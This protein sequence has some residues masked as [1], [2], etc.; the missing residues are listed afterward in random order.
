MHLPWINIASQYYNHSTMKLAFNFLVFTTFNVVRVLADPYVGFPFDEQLP[1]IAR[2]G[3]NYNFII[4]SQTFKS[5]DESSKIKYEAFD[6]PEWLSFDSTSLSLSGL[7]GDDQ[8]SGKIDFILQGSDNQSSSNQSCSIYLSN[9]PSPQLNNDNTVMQQLESIGYT[10]GYN[11]IILTPQEPFKITF[12]KNT[13]EI[14]SSSNN[15]IIAYY[16]KSANRTS[17]PSWCFFDE[18]SL[19]FSGVAPAINSVDAPSMEFD[20]TLIATDY[21]GFSAIYSDFSIVVGG[22]SLYIKNS[23][24]YEASIMTNVGDSFQIDLP[25]DEIYL[26]DDLIQ[27]NQIESVQNYNGPS[28]VE[29]V[30]NSKIIGTVPSDQTS[31]TV[32]NVTLFDIYGDSIFMNFDINVLHNVF[33]IDSISNITAN[34]GSF[35]KFTLPD[36][37]FLNE[38]ATEL[39]VSFDADWLT[40]YHSNNTFIGQVP[41]NF[42]YVLVELDATINNMKQSMKFFI[43]GKPLTSSSLSFYSSSSSSS[44]RSSSMYS[45]KITSSASFVS[46]NY[47]SMI[48]LTKSFT[49]SD[50]SSTSTTSLST[51][52]TSS[53]TLVSPNNNNKGTNSDTK[54]KIAIALGVAIPLIAIIVA[55]IFIF[56]CCCAKRRKNS[57]DDDEK[58][59]DP[60]TNSMFMNQ[61][62]TS[63]STLTM[64]TTSARFLAE[65]NLNNLEKDDDLQSSYY[66]NAQ[67]TLTDESNQNLYTSANQQ[68]STDHLLGKHNQ[69]N[70]DSGIFNSWRKSSNGNLMTRDSLNSLATVATSDLLTVNVVSND[71]IRKSQMMLPSLSKLR[72]INNST[73]SLFDT[74]TNRTN[75]KD[76]N[77]NLPPLDENEQ[78]NTFSRDSS[79]NSLNSEAQL[80]GFENC[81][82]CSKNIQ[83]EEKSYHA[84][85][86]N[87]NNYDNESDSSERL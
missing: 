72:N 81:G 82:S 20:L 55:G 65:K 24:Y 5:N 79:Y 84:E 7:P 40:F 27:S 58:P 75:S 52:P 44:S 8:N 28:W 83:R 60:P 11:G 80:I 3:E 32:V 53:D 13:F 2:I 9:Q 57:N 54:K 63:N 29:I 69:S 19:T 15:E 41:Q 42:D 73:D 64:D 49:T 48:S 26:D 38:T 6:L 71:K 62:N 33:A 76:F 47:S 35:F 85:I 21:Q 1:D 61:P 77:F 78:E 51:I 17:L 86:Y 22:H 10:N 50:Q 43:V 31:N 18:S 30:D 4:N 36:S 23:T 16:G 46:S 14:P 68:M 12:D 34:D 70:T 56:F 74:E 67:S 45:S 66:S 37:Y 59:D 25:I 39:S 87:A